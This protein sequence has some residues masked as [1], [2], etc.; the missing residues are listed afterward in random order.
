MRDGGRERSKLIGGFRVNSSTG[1]IDTAVFVSICGGK[2]MQQ[3]GDLTW[4][5]GGGVRGA[6]GTALNGLADECRCV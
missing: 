2:G 4:I 6:R 3:Y 5:S 1:F